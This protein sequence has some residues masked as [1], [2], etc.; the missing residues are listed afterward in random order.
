[1][2]ILI[3]TQILLNSGSYPFISQLEI[4]ELYL[5][6]LLLL[7]PKLLLKTCSLPTMLW[8]IFV[9]QH[10]RINTITP[11]P[12][13]VLKT[14]DCEHLSILR[15]PT[16][17]LQQE[18]PWKDWCNQCFRRSWQ[19]NTVTQSPSSTLKFLPTRGH[20]VRRVCIYTL[21]I[22]TTVCTY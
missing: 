3:Q 21:S 12:L 17:W 4:L 8:S 14:W 19:P 13:C 2:L 10:T 18:G 1:M 11:K 22:M 5:I 20:G 9:R 6:H 16:R 7:K 15:P